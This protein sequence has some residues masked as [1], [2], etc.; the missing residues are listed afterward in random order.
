[1]NP[2]SLAAVLTVASAMVAV[3]LVANVDGFAL[4]PALRFGLTVGKAGLT[5][6]VATLPPIKRRIIPHG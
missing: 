1:M 5:A 4:D 6:A 2:R 3:A